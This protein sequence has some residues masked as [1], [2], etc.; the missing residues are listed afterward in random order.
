MRKIPFNKF[1]PGTR[2]ENM[3]RLFSDNISLDGEEIPLDESIIMKLS[4]ETGKIKQIS[5]FVQDEINLFV[6]I[7]S[8]SEIKVEGTLNNLLTSELNSQL[9]KI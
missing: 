4:H 5:L 2:K 9:N 6:H 3:Y 1:N 8:N 7:N